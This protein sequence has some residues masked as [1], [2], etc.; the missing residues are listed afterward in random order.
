M[1]LESTT[2]E[3]YGVFIKGSWA[4]PRYLSQPLQGNKTGICIPDMFAGGPSE[5]QGF[6]TTVKLEVY[7]VEEIYLMMLTSEHVSRRLKDQVE[8]KMIVIQW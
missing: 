1:D 4:H 6:R 7:Q 3:S 2:S 8:R 5:H